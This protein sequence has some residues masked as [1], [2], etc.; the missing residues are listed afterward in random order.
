MTYK[1]GVSINQITNMLSNCRHNIVEMLD[2]DLERSINSWVKDRDTL[3]GLVDTAKFIAE[4]YINGAVKMTLIILMDNAIYTID[5][6]NDKIKFL[7]QQNNLE[8]EEDVTEPVAKVTNNEVAIFDDPLIIEKNINAQ[9]PSISNN[10]IQVQRIFKRSKKGYSFK[11]FLY[12]ENNEEMHQ[13]TNNELKHKSYRGDISGFQR[14][15]S[16]KGFMVGVASIIDLPD[17][18]RK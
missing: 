2:S 15:L 12:F 10:F 4:R 13:L 9:T 17:M 6:I 16:D 3:K 7:I 11:R 14:F 18:I 1:L 5:D 8:G